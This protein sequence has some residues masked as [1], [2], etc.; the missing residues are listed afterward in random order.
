M[1]M[2][3]CEECDVGEEGHEESLAG[4]HVEANLEAEA[5]TKQGGLQLFEIA[6]VY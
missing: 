1:S 5:R 6:R 3:P 4:H 2:R